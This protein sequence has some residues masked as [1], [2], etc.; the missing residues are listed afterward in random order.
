MPPLIW[1]CCGGLWFV[2]VPFI[3]TAKVEVS[4]AVLLAVAALTALLV[5][6]AAAVR[7]CPRPRSWAGGAVG[8]AVAM[9][10]AVGL[11]PLGLGAAAREKHATL[12]R[13]Y[14]DAVA[15]LPGA[16]RD[17]SRQQSFQVWDNARRVLG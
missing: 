8:G 2:H 7:R 4:C 17:S 16:V 10:L 11:G 15:S 9:A 6:G 14:E 1:K 13:R 3:G 12:V 5:V